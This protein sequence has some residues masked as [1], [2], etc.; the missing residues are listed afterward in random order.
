MNAE[1]GQDPSDVIGVVIVDDHEVFR[2]GLEVAFSIEDDLAVVGQA[3]TASDAV[4][5]VFLK[6][7]D[8]V[9][10]DLR[11]PDHSGMVATEA[12]K[13]KQPNTPVVVLTASD[14]EDDLVGALRAG[15][16]GYV[17]KT[18]PVDEV[19]DAVRRAH[20]GE[21]V[22]PPPM[23]THLVSAFSR[24]AAE[25][26]EETHAAA[27]LSA[28]ELEVLGL[29]ARGLTNREIARALTLSENTVKNH[30]RN[31][32]KKLEVGTRTEAVAR[33]LRDGLISLDSL[34]ERTG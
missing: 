8:V 30:L 13:D 32:M 16:D 34:P 22:V 12:I 6:Q 1:S 18:L 14:D 9:L 3:A 23:L 29:V 31:L 21:S 2:R 33:S 10:M 17:V 25:A 5:E 19:A 15:A 28:R 4:Q 24:V 26:D 20:A 7:P 27:R 11:L